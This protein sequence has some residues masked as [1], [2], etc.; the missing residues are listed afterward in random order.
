MGKLN[1]ELNA[2]PELFEGTTVFDSPDFY[3]AVIGHTEDG[4]IIYSYDLMVK[5]MIADLA[6]IAF[7]DVDGLSGDELDEK[8]EEAVEWIDYNTIRTI[9]YM[10]EKSPI[11]S[12]TPSWS[13]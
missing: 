4:R 13:E 5:C 10:G 6:C 2:Q 12:Y 9:P 7:S 1:D 3:E 8:Y 11:I